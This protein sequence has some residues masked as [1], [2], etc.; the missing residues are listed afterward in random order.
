MCEWG[1]ERGRD[2]RT[3]SENG[4]CFQEQV[5]WGVKERI[6]KYVIVRSHSKLKQLTQW[7]PCGSY[8]AAHH[9][10]QTSHPQ[11]QAWPRPLQWVSLLL[12][13]DSYWDIMLVSKWLTLETVFVT[14]PLSLTTSPSSSSLQGT[15]LHLPQVGKRGVLLA[16]KINKCFVD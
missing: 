12:S 4:W 10:K 15:R 2:L 7:K 6:W 3:H 5:L 9:R 14:Q 16:L 1:P 8:R 13:S 11:P